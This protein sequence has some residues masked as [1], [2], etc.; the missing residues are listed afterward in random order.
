MKVALVD[1]DSRGANA[2]N[3][4]AVLGPVLLQAPQNL[5]NPNN[6]G[7]VQVENSRFA[8]SGGQSGLDVHE[9]ARYAVH[10]AD[11]FGVIIGTSQ[12]M[13]ILAALPTSGHCTD[14]TDFL[15]V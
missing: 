6:L 13:L 14:L 11:Y 10:N 1:L 8:V 4:N 15:L 3:V 9:W 12:V 5:P 2:N 7:F